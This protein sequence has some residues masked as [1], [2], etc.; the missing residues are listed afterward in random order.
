MEGTMTNLTLLRLYLF[1]KNV[2]LYILKSFFI[3]LITQKCSLCSILVPLIGTT[4][5]LVEGG[6]RLV[7]TPD[8]N[9]LE[10]GPIVATDTVIGALHFCVVHVLPSIAASQHIIYL[11][12][13]Q[14]HLVF[15]LCLHFEHV[16]T[17]LAKESEISH[18]LLSKENIRACGAKQHLCS[19][20]ECI[21][22][23]QY[24]FI[25]V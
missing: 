17:S 3:S 16:G 13:V 14:M 2:G 8:L 9:L 22:M 25:F 6:H 11:L 1:C 15:E 21:V 18:G 5:A 4:G 23:Y 19:L 12:A 10:I 20:S 7:G 24:N